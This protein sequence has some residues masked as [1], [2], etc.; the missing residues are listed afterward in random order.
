[1][2]MD[3]LALAPSTFI[4]AAAAHRRACAAGKF[5]DRR[6]P[7]TREDFTAHPRLAR[8]TRRGVWQ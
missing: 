3:D 5:N 7:D 8:E 2:K 6:F 4:A 1:M